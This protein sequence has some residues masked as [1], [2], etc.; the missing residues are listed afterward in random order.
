MV[1]EHDPC[2]WEASRAQQFSVDRFSTQAEITAEGPAPQALPVLPIAPADNPGSPQ[3]HQDIA[4]LHPPKTW[5][6]LVLPIQEER[7]RPGLGI[8]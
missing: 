8:G 7:Q 4:F 3:M 1:L 6:I 2:H 5:E